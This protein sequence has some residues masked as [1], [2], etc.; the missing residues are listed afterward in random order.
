MSNEVLDKIKSRGHWEVIIRPTVFSKERLSSFAEAEQQLRA[1]QVTFRGWY[2]P[3]MRDVRRGLDFIEESVSFQA[4]HET[5]RFYQSGQLVFYRGLTEDWSEEAGYTPAYQP[6][7]ALS[8]LSAL[9]AVSEIFEFATRLAQ[10]G[11]LT[12]EGLIKINLVGTSGRTLVFWGSDRILFRE[13]TCRE[14]AL[15]RSWTLPAER[16]M[17]EG[18]DLAFQHFLWLM[19]RFGFDA[20]PEVFRADQEKFFRGQF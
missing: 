20:S 3:H 7:A 16:L 1:C 12:P 9:Y 14:E 17:T 4:I 8:I 10:R 18:R 13:Y 15:P 5:W 6:G 19:E 2:F 11:V